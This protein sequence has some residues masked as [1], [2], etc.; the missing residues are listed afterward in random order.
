V[1]AGLVQNPDLRVIQ[2]V[3]EPVYQ[4]EEDVA[5]L[6]IT[7]DLSDSLTLTSLTSWSQ[8]EYYT[9]QDYNRI[10]PVV[11]FN[12]TLLTPGGVF[13]DPQLGCFDRLA[14]ADISA[15]SSEQFTQE[16]RLQS[17]FDGPLNFSLGAIMID[18]EAAPVDY[19]V[20][21][22]SL[23]IGAYAFG[24]GAF[25]DLQNPPTGNGRNYYLNRTRS[26]ELN[27]LAFM[28]EVYWEAFDGFT[29][30]GGVRYTQDEKTVVS[31]SPILLTA[32]PV[33]I[34]NQ[35]ATFE[36]VTGRLG[37]DWQ[38]DTGFTDQTL[39]YAFYSRGYKGGGFNPPSSVGIAGIT[40]T[41][42]PE[43]VNAYEV[44]VKNT[45]FDGSMIFNATAFMYD[46]EG[47]QI[48]KIVNRSS[49][50]ENID[51]EVRGA[52]FELVWEPF[53]GFRI[54]GT[55]GLLDTEITGGDSIDVF[56]RIQG[57]PGWTLI[58]DPLTAQ[59]CLAPTAFFSAL[60]VGTINAAPGALGNACAPAGNFLGL[61]AWD[62][63]SPL[64]P[65]NTVQSAGP[66]IGGG[67]PL[68][69][70][71]LPNAPNWTISFGAEYTWPLGGG[72]EATARADYYEQDSSF[73]R[74]FNSDADTLEGYM[75]LNVLFRVANPNNGLAIEAFVQ[76]VTDEVAITDSYL[77]DDSSGLFRNIFLTDPRIFGLRASAEF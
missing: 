61:T 15:A 20:M 10:V 32:A 65:T 6:N 47:Y 38:I 34:S 76:N 60:V 33:V 7:V 9:F 24:L 37:F 57:T 69:G 75:N 8:D 51:A 13:C 3:F 39:L 72:W 45:L 73:M 36:E 48:S 31:V 18:F 50:N 5:L 11:P 66:I 27:S 43:F 29:L 44:G 74:I 71:E 12:A 16:L 42:D 68:E 53:T 62:G 23:T 30:T 40:D 4:A 77:T 67:V 25:V 41:F 26:Y 28:G 52:E 21:S 54:N 58:H 59:N 63:V 46:Y 55:L 14:T 70:N 49:V 35:N 1:N 22:N 17:D 64:L 19:W 56:D 2:S